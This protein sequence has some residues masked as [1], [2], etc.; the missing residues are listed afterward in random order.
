MPR[1]KIDLQLRLP[2]NSLGYV[3]ALAYARACPPTPG[4]PPPT[5]R[6]PSADSLDCGAE[7]R[8]C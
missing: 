4:G 1:P 7:R 5:L 6:F 8:G 2:W 3:L